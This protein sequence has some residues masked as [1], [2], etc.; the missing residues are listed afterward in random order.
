MGADAPAAHFACIFRPGI[1]NKIN[2]PDSP[3]A[4]MSL[5]DHLEELRWRILKAMIGLVIATAISLFF[6][7]DFISLLERP[8]E[9]AA[10]NAG[11]PNH[12]LTVM[13]AS[14][15]F[16]TYM[17]VAIIAGMLLAAPW[18]FY[19]LWAFIAAGLYPHERKHITYAVPFSALL[20]ISGALLFLFYVSTPTLQFF[21]TFNS[22]L[23]LNPIVTLQNHIKFMT[24]LMFVFGLSF[25]T[26]LVILFLSKMGIVRAKNIGKYR[27]HMI[28]IILIIAAFAT[29]PSPVDQ[30]A[31]AVPIYLLFELGIILAKISE[32]NKL[33]REQ[34]A[35]DD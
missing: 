33:T 18:T 28:L 6:T 10:T 31:L 29:S 24:T 20:F 7:K 22:W 2:H 1:V 4:K 21:A 3:D 19:Q 8:Y 32:R 26:P 35:Q 13:N 14:A 27:P 34:E 9:A 15:G 25:Q 23:G 17:R 16:T 12:E 5:G 30:I 11:L